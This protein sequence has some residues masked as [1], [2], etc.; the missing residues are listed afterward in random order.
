MN[1]KFGITGVAP[2]EGHRSMPRLMSA[3][4][5]TP[6]SR[7]K[8][9]EKIATHPE[10]YK[11]CEGC[12]SIVVARAVTCPSCHAYMFDNTPVRVIAQAKE[13]ALRA[14]NSVLASDLS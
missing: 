11:V 14:A 1:Q 3:H 2:Y 8:Q 4:E 10:Q 5:H 13:L 12:G 9:A 6:D 7:L